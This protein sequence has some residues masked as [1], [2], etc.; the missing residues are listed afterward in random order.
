MFSKFFI[1]RP[2]FAV[3]VSVVIVLA[4]LVLMGLLPIAQYPEIAPPQV[5]VTASYPGA[6]AAVLAE[7]VAEPIESQVNGVEGMIYMSSTSSNNGDYTL[8]V[9]FEVGTD[10]DVA[11]V[12]VQNRVSQIESQL[13]QEVQRLGLTVSKRAS[14]LF[15]F[16]ALISPDDRFDPLYLSNYA[17]I[18]MVDKLKRIE[19]MG[20]VM[21]YGAGDYA[22]RVWLDPEQLDARGLTT[23]DVL[24]AIREQNVQVAAGQLGQMPGGDNPAFQLAVN[25][26]GRLDEVAEFEEIIVKT[27]PGGRQVYMKDIARVELSARSYDVI[28]KTDGRPSTSIGMVLKPGANVV[29]VAERAREEMAALSK[30]FPEGMEAIIPFDATT[31]V[32]VAIDE[33]IETLFITVILVVLVILVFLQNWRAILIPV[34][35]I[36]VSLIGTLAVMYAMGIS[37]NMLSLFG[38][39]LAIGIVVDDAIVVVENVMR[40]IDESNMSPREATVLAMKEVTGP[41]IATTLVLA[42]VF[43]PTAFMAGSTGQLYRQFALTIT[44]ATV[45]SAINALTLSP[46]LSAVLLRPSSTQRLNIFARGFNRFFDGVQRVYG[47]MVAVLLRRTALMLILFTGI[48]AAATYGFITLPKGFVPTEDQGWALVSIQLPDAASLNRT[49][50]VM[51]V[52]DKKLEE[53]PGVKHFVS[54][55]GY[56]VIDSAMVSN[57]AVAWVVF[58]DWNERLETGLTLD[59]LIGQLWGALAPIQEAQIFAFPPPAIL[60]MGNAGGFNMEIQDRN[61]LG[62]EILQEETLNLM[63]AANQDPRLAQAFTTFRATVPQVEADVDRTK[64]KSMGIPRTD[65]YQTLQANLGSAYVNDFSAYGKTFQVRVQADGSFRKHPDQIRDLKVRNRDGDMVPLGAVVDINETLGAQIIN[66]YN[67]YPAAMMSGQGAPGISSGEVMD[68]MAEL[69]EETLS[70]GMGFE[71]TN[72]SYQEMQARGKTLAVLIM[73]VLFVYLVLCAQYESWTLPL[74]VILSVP[75]ALLGTVTAV[76]VRGMDINV[77]TQIGLVLLV[78]LTCKT[79]ILITEFAKASRDEGEGIL[80]AAMKAATIRFRPIL[81]TALTF[82]L[83]MV[84]LVIATG[85]GANSRQALGTAV[86]SGMLSAMLLLIFFVPA[87]YALIQKISEA[88]GKQFKTAGEPVVES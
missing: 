61:N 70:P 5:Q 31:F 50:D 84:P 15:M 54:F 45:F 78:A 59:T 43:V 3:V 60:G 38:I 7:T 32:E 12:L 29:E 41:I 79:A 68:I 51:D 4:G 34:A 88:V 1:D 87:F 22:M 83:G 75:L 8:S 58:D 42:S 64:T 72:M 67:L 57:A 27:L 17:K 82:I 56:S 49:R 16:A 18:N 36:P 85:A 47:N 77:Y 63:M 11:Q 20:D 71:W 23:S 25:V 73:A 39:V 46:A 9:S 33:V 53:M 69:A 76:F 19:G 55:T 62:L 65:V 2:I 10:M 30:D 28:S 52:V 40:H 14:T 26:Q 21:L 44:V 48:T 81:M 74:S 37:I 35:T 66:R 13:P 6:S 80:E 86:F 24:N